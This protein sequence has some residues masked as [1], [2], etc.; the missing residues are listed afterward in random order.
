MPPGAQ[1][2]LQQPQSSRAQGDG[3]WGPHQ[4]NGGAHGDGRQGP[5]PPAYPAT[6]PTQ[7]HRVYEEK[8][9]GTDLFAIA[10]ADEPSKAPDHNKKLILMAVAA[11]AAVV[12]AI[13]IVAALG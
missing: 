10:G 5:Y 6:A 8:G 3:Q 13:L 4:Q 1:A 11:A 2:G 9:L 12:V 7:Q